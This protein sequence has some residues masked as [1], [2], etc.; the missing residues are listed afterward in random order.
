MF[1]EVTTLASKEIQPSMSMVPSL[2]NKLQEMLSIPLES[3]GAEQLRKKFVTS[4]NVRL[5]WM[6]T[7]VNVSL[8]AA[9]FD[10]EYAALPFVDQKIKD[11]TWS[12]LIGEGNLIN[13]Q[14][15]ENSLYPNITTVEAELK[16]LRTFFE[17]KFVKDDGYPGVLGWWKNFKNGERLKHLAAKF[18]AIPATSTPSERAF[19]CAG[20]IYNQR[21]ANLDEDTVEKLVFIRDNMNLI[22]ENICD[23][24]KSYF[25]KRNIEY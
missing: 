10:P 7:E 8:Q 25:S 19:S 13:N 24:L 1:E 2:V 17:K 16:E 21:R 15:S 20:F 22:P 11:S 4:V 12:S 18:L 3:E 6:L 5:G 14:N 9:C 23:L